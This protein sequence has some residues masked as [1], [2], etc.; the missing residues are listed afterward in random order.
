MGKKTKGK[1]K[2]KTGKS[3]VS[4]GTGGSITPAK[5]SADG[6]M[7]EKDGRRFYDLLSFLAEIAVPELEVRRKDLLKKN[8]SPIGWKTFDFNRG[9]RGLAA[10]SMEIRDMVMTFILKE[11]DWLVE[12]V[13]SKRHDSLFSRLFNKQLLKDDLVEIRSWKLHVQDDFFYIT[14]RPN[15]GAVFVQC[16]LLPGSKL[17]LNPMGEWQKAEIHEPRVFVVRGLADPLEKLLKG[18]VD[19]FRLENPAIALEHPNATVGFIKTIL[20][21]Y[22]GGITYMSTMKQPDNQRYVSPKEMA[23]ATNLAIQAARDAFNIDNTNSG[24]NDTGITVPVYHT[25]NFETDY[26]VCRLARDNQ[27]EAPS[28]LQFPKGVEAAR[29]TKKGDSKNATTTHIIAQQMF[30][31]PYEKQNDPRTDDTIM[32]I[33]EGTKPFL[34]EGMKKAVTQEILINDD[35]GCP[36]HNQ[37]AFGPEAT[38]S[39]KDC[40]KDEYRRRRLKAGKKHIP[41]LISTM[42]EPIEPAE[43]EI[44]STISQ[45]PQ[46]RD[47]PVDLMKFMRIGFMDTGMVRFKIPQAHIQMIKERLDDSPPFHA[48]LNTKWIYLGFVPARMSLCGI[49]TFGDLELFPETGIFE[50]NA[51]TNRR[52]TALIREMKHVCTGIPILDAAIEMQPSHKMKPDKEALERNQELLQEGLELDVVSQYDIN[53]KENECMRKMCA[54]CGANEKSDGAELSRCPCKLVYFCSVEHQ[55]AHWPN[56]KVECKRARAR[57]KR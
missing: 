18:A 54:Y 29:K 12:E 48:V 33:C 5:I 31:Q 49:M 53:K 50:G 13:E 35:E 38:P 2:G 47:T 6:R 3:K 40:C 14:N 20:L 45:D 15:E 17:T 42:Y 46:Y 44:I 22:K 56:H 16:G 55:R 41:L 39:F 43:A 52:L 9:A 24:G 28:E 26:H 7:S 57:A 36:F 19:N 10:N 27:R 37:L 8:Y 4:N 1:G 34:L 32:R 21:P 11:I 51:M 25:L 23:D 30:W